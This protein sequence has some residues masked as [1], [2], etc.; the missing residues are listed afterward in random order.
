[1]ATATMIHTRYFSRPVLAPTHPKVVDDLAHG[2][3][4]PTLS[5]TLPVCREV[6]YVR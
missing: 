1:M 3:P 6:F 2:A 5:G 4:I